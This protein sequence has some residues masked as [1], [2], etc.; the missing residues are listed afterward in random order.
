[1]TS[2]EIRG[3]EAGVRAELPGFQVWPS[4]LTLRAH[5]FE[6]WVARGTYA[7]DAGP[8]AI[9]GSPLSS[10]HLEENVEIYGGFAGWETERSQR[11]WHTQ[12]S[13]LTA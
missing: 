6:I 4:F 2:A 3:S 12:L 7:P 13:I 1:M 10:F 8:G 11:D 9:A 5:N